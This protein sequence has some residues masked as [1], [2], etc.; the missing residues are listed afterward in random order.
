MSPPWVPSKSCAAICAMFLSLV[1]KCTEF[2]DSTPPPKLAVER[3]DDK[4]TQEHTQQ[5]T[6]KII[7]NTSSS[8]KNKLYTY[9][10]ELKT[11]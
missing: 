11:H 5:K 1:C 3:R 7:L 6:E 2:D 8:Q 4:K 9:T 10:V